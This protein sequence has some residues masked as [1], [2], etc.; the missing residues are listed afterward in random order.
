MQK[1]FCV[2]LSMTSRPDKLW[3]EE[4][5]VALVRSLAAR[6][7]ESLLPWGSQAE[8]ARCCRIAAAAGAG[9]VPRAMSLGELASQIKDAKAVVGVDTGLAHLAVALGVPAIGLYCGSDPALTGLH[10]GA[11]VANLGGP[12][13]VPSAQDAL[14]ALEAMG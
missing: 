6:G 9:I 3:P 10:G 5:W 14:A 4:H 13:R 12:G 7:W 1:P 11:T 8:Q 2:L